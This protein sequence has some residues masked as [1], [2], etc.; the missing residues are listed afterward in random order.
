VNIRNLRITRSTACLLLAFLPVLG[1][2]ADE[3]VSSAQPST[4]SCPPGTPAVCSCPDLRM[5]TTTCLPTGDGFAACPCGAAPTAQAGQAG[6]LAAGHGASGSLGIGGLGTAG[7]SSP[8]ASG[9]GG[10][11]AGTAG[12]SGAAAVGGGGEAG[13]LG[14][15]GARAAA[16]TSGAAG[17][18]SAGAG[19]ATAGASGSSPGEPDLMALCAGGTWTGMP[20]DKASARAQGSGST[21]FT[22]ATSTEITRLQ[23]TM[24]VPPKPKPSGTVFLWP[25]LQPLP[26]GKSYQPIGNGVLQ[27]V[28][29]WGSTCAAG[30][31]NDYKSW[32]ISGQYVNVSSRESAHMGCHGGDGMDVDVD[33]RLVIDMSRAG[34]VWTQSVLDAKTGKSVKFDIDMAGQAQNWAIFDIE[35]PT[36]T[37]PAGD[38]VFANT[39]ITMAASSPMSCQPDSR[40][41]TDYFTAPRASADGTICCID[42]IVLRA[43]GVT[44]TTPNGP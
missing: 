32:W 10:A 1:C 18:S 37:K 31:P 14:T 4:M 19:A 24:I 11:R 40:G 33:D 35:L 41:S 21:T 8:F 16:G 6:A 30:A 38:L 39:V 43:S 2:S 22:V 29:T 34:T 9:S 20:S 3:P 28:L 23:T 17:V 25:G 5:T 44:M 27:P 26:N 13:G 36:S 12:A 7:V 42:R 15:A